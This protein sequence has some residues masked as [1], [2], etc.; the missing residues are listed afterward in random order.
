MGPNCLS[1][2]KFPEGLIWQDP[3]P[4]GNTGFDVAAV[5]A[6]IRAAGLTVQK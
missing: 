6:A 1:R 5:K 4:A 3:V 2:P